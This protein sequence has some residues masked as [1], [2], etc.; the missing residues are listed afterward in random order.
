MAV[1]SSAAPAELPSIVS[2][3]GPPWKMFGFLS[4]RRLSLLIPPFT[5]SM[6]IS[7]SSA[8]PPIFTTLGALPLRVTV[9][10]WS[11]GR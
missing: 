4:P 2:S 3:P 7:V 1:S 9:M 8:T 10:G 6:P 5:F 11:R